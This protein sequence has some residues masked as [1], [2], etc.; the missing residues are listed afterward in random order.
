MLDRMPSWFLKHDRFNSKS[1]IKYLRL[2]PLSVICYILWFIYHKHEESDLAFSVDPLRFI[3]RYENRYTLI[4]EKV[5]Q[6]EKK[7]RWF[8]TNLV[9]IFEKKGWGEITQRF[10]NFRDLETNRQI[11]SYNTYLTLNLSKD[12]FS[13]SEP[14]D[15][16][17]IQI[18]SSKHPLPKRYRPYGGGLSFGFIKN[19][20]IVCFAA[21]PHILSQETFSFAILRG[22][23]TKIIERRQRYA[24]KTVGVLCKELFSRY[25]LA[26]IFLWVDEKN[27]AARNLY[28]KLGFSEEGKIYTTYCDQKK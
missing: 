3:F 10:D 12:H 9:L 22:I 6:L 11:D 24:L 7:V 2:Q 19:G 1:F 18:P 4:G 14:I 5:W 25:N 28:Q 23:E 20:K 27:I 15:N 8:E 13:I 17:I 16:Q 21:A 26:N